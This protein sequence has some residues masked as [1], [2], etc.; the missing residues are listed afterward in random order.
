V[1]IPSLPFNSQTLILHRVEE[2]SRW[3][4]CS[5]EDIE[6]DHG[7]IFYDSP[8]PDTREQIH[9]NELNN[10]PMLD[11]TGAQ[12]HIYTED[13]FRI[14]RRLAGF[15]PNVRPHGVLLNLRDV[16]LL[17]KSEESDT[18]FSV[19]PQAGLVTVGHIQAEGL[20]SPYAPLLQKLN[21][22]VRVQ[23]EED[24]SNND[25]D[26]STNVPI[27]GIACQ[28]YNALMHNTRGRT[29][30][31]HDAQRGLVTAAL[32][33]G[34]AKSDSNVRKARTLQNQCRTRLPHLEFKEKI[35]NNNDQPLDCSLRFEN[36]FVI[37][38]DQLN[39][40]YHD[41]GFVFTSLPFL[42]LLLMLL[43]LA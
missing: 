14:Q 31:H 18:P 11:D 41:G 39:P 27:I 2:V 24:H 12:I 17:F 28:A 35:A 9:L 29:A 40:V 6:N 37:H 21:S 25:S 33:G 26:L 34:Y 8:D 13:G 32:A 15:G 36:T 1:F 42:N 23:D 5:L 10:L 43:L 38:M 30:Q 22:K 19:F 16:G 3:Q 7:N 4:E 20:V